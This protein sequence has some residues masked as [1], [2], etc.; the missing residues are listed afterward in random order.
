MNHFGK[1]YERHFN[2]FQYCIFLLM[3]WMSEL[4]IGML[5]YVYYEE[6]E[7]DLSRNLGSA[8]QIQ[9]FSDGHED[10]TAMID[11]MQKQVWPG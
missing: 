7:T 9:Y 8:F 2:C 10:I 11:K 3:I 6:V 4:V 1:K 5:G